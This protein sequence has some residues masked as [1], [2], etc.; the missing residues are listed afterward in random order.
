[1]KRIE[2]FEFEDF[3]WLPG[4]IR[5]GVTNLIRVFHRLIG[6][7]D[8]LVDLITECRKKIS[9]TQ[10]VDL[11]SGSGGPMIGVIE[12]INKRS[13]GENPI[14]LLL[15]DKYPNVKT[16]QQINNLKIPYVTYHA[17]SLDALE[18]GNAPKGLKT[19]IASFH[20]MK[21]K[22]A[23]RILDAAEKK[24]EPILIYEIAENNIPVV[25]WCLL[26]PLSLVIL[27][28]MSLIMTPFVRRLTATQLI[29]TYIIPIIP[30]VYAWDGQASI[31]RTYT[32][33]D[34]KGLIGERDNESYTWEVSPA[35]KRNGKKAGYYIFGYPP[36]KGAPPQGI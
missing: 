12:E 27:V 28:I 13:T 4:F 23:R 24:K 25:L 21:P 10:I 8:V 33:E 32:F 36:T 15:S 6:T 19:M 20:H 7:S 26:L 9:F 30:V 17:N 3:N 31:M 11:G 1:M 5:T 2:L 14:N 22:I 35:I 29:F 34:I 18:I 16:V